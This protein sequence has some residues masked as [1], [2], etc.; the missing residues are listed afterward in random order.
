[1]ADG[2]PARPKIAAIATT[3]YKYSHAQHIVDRFLEGHRWAGRFR[4]PAVDLVSLYVDQV[5]S[6][7]LS[8]ERARRYPQMTIY[9]SIADALTLGGSE[10]AVDGVLL[11]AEHG[12]YPKNRKGQKLYPRA[13]F[14]EQIV[15]VFR[16]SGRTAPVFNDKHMSYDWT[17]ARRM[18]DL[19]RELGFAFMAGSSLPV[20]YRIPAVDV[21]AGAGVSEAMGLGYGNLDSYDIHVFETIQCMVERRAGGE[22][23]VR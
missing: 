17:K 1:M 23:G 21:P 16:A 15:D 9:P 20:T 8:R 13:Q 6:R 2:M 14:F 19:S 5:N 7:D 11:V 10:L 12:T 22:T 3:Y 4:E 18:Y